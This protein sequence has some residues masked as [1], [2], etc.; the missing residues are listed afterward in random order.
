LIELPVCQGVVGVLTGCTGA[1][2]VGVFTIGLPYGSRFPD[3][4]D[5]VTI[6]LKELNYASFIVKTQ[7]EG[8]ICACT[9]K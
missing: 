5:A 8:M 6:D 9:H 7:L 4:D 2:L 3:I 1:G